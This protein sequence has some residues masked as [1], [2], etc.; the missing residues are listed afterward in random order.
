MHKILA[1]T[2]FLG[3]DIVYLTE[4][5]S[6]NDI[7]VQKVKEGTA[8]EGSIIIT[9]KQT[10]GKGQ[11]GNR[12]FSEPSVN[13][14]FSLVLSPYFLTPVEQFE[15]NRI[16]SLAVREELS[17]YSTGIKVKWP[18]DIVHESEGKIGGILIENTI[19][20]ERIESSVVGIG[21]NINQTEFPFPG[22]VSMANL[23]GRQLEKWEILGGILAN[24]E[25]KYIQLKK[26]Q[27]SNLHDEYYHH[28]Y[29]KEL[30]A[31]YED[32]QGVF[33]GKIIGVSAA[34]L[35]KMKKSDESLNQYTFKEVKF[36]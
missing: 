19:H 14:T 16:V 24:L 30:W 6:T 3:K 2:V 21:L 22:P 7:A 23:A 34:G 25:K 1:N 28:L 27:L 33:E 10:K 13:L 31:N 36:L 17:K 11:R 12:W 9:D 26:R 32:S 15:L 18:N 35:L 20:K 29:R 4:C 8:K 5:H